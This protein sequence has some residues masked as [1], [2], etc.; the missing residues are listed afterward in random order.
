MGEFTEDGQGV[1]LKV[2]PGA[3][4]TPSND[5]YIE[6]P[7]KRF[8]NYFEVVTAGR[9]EVV[10]FDDVDGEQPVITLRQTDVFDP[11]TSTYYPVGNSQ[12]KNR[13]ISGSISSGEKTGTVTKAPVKVMETD[14]FALKDS[15]LPSVFDSYR[16]E[17]NAKR[18]MPVYTVGDKN[19]A[20]GTKNLGNVDAGFDDDS[21]E[22]LPVNPYEIS[23]KPSDSEDGQKAAL[24][25]F[26]AT[27]G[28]NEEDG[29]NAAYPSALLYAASRGD[30]DAQK[31]LERLAKVGRD[32]M[33]VQKKE[34]EE[35]ALGFKKN[36]RR[37]DGE[38]DWQYEHPELMV[39]TGGYDPETG[40]YKQ[41]MLDIDD[42]FL[43]HQTSYEP[44]TDDDGNIILRPA[45]E[46]EMTDPETGKTVMDPITGETAKNYR[47]TVHFALNH[48]V[49]G[50]MYRQTPTAKT[51]AV[52]VPL[53]SMLEQNEGALDNLY[54]IDTYMTPKP[55]EGL[56]IPK[57][58]GR[59]VEIPGLEDRGI[60]KP[61]GNPL[62]DW[63]QEQREEIDAA[64]S[65][66][67]ASSQ[68]LIF[69]MLQATAREHNGSDEYMLRMF[70]GGM[71]GSSEGVDKRVR[72]IA[73]GLGVP[74]GKHDSTPNQTFEQITPNSDEA[75]RQLS[76]IANSAWTPLWTMN[77][78]ARLRLANNDRFTSGNTE[79]IRED[80]TE[81]F[82]I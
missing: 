70:E 55:G 20:F 19:I 79:T 63:T 82:W 12:K 35:W 31:E 33:E 72:E 51:Y 56:K 78:N 3:R 2:L 6:N 29:K 68:R 50:H 65:E 43:V 73:V 58:A 39:T 62:T 57:G 41:R 74:A 59:V 37:P 46:F 66:M 16:A 54:A 23:G 52:M 21:V 81:D 18:S 22:I 11:V 71:H 34:Y 48:M 9:F 64:I 10:E 76:S 80:R 27:V 1:I 38:W 45:E 77:E 49:Q 8:D 47:G 32:A 28:Q 61:E 69:E 40:G 14:E 36:S 15:G 24:L 75:S 4:S 7:Q 44:T 17:S 26:E 30:D 53:R 42:I 25:W 13:G 67:N 5:E 60:K